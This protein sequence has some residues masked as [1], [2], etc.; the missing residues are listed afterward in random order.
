MQQIL[1]YRFNNDPCGITLPLYPQIKHIF[2]GNNTSY[3]VFP[4]DLYHLSSNTYI[5]LTI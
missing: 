2:P 4:I 5:K 3:A 1:V